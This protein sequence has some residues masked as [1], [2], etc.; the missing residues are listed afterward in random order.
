VDGELALSFLAEHSVAAN[1]LRTIGELEGQLPMDAGCLVLAE[2]AL[3]D[4][5]AQ[6]LRHL[7]EAQ[8]SWSDVPLVLIASEGRTLS[9]MLD[10]TFPQA[11]NVTMLERPVHPLTLVSAVRVG[12]RA[13][14]RQL[15]VHQLLRER[16]HALQQRDDFMAMLAHELRNPLAPM[17]NAV[18]LQKQ[19]STQDPAITKTRDMLDRQVN[20]MSRM[21]D[22]LMDLARLDR[23]KIELQLQPLDLN[24]AVLAALDATATIIREKAHVIETRL[25]SEPLPI[26][27]DPVRL[28]QL[29]SNLLVNAC[30]F[31]P[32]GGRIEVRT[33]RQG[34]TVFASVTDN[35][36]GMKPEQIETLFSPFVQ[37]EGSLARTTGGLGIGLSIARAIA[38][39]HRGALHARSSGP[40]TGAVFE[41][42]LPRAEPRAES[43]RQETHSPAPSASQRILIIEDNDDIRESLRMVLLSWGHEVML[44]PTGNEGLAMALEM[45]P[46]VALID[47]GLPGLS[48]F[49]VARRIRASTQLGASGIHL[50]AMT[51]YGAPVDRARA[52]EAGFEQHLLKPVDPE[53][54]RPLL[55][56]RSASA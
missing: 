22:D 4:T 52:A 25:A 26:E 31:T 51:G 56:S 44:A 19:S 14:A 7:L 46:D 54:L 18:Y 42:A 28:E 49:D 3:L 35:G 30:K 39:L 43:P 6:S 16:E 29:L 40:N 37:G 21:V 36:V 15:Q 33:R 9:A 34:Q 55:R 12:L 5:D 38:K 47:I 45:K 23:G 20:H 48:G 32:S 24:A 10:L 2:E 53:A 27:A 17:R 11:G 13:R 41:V 50:I 1:T 8:P